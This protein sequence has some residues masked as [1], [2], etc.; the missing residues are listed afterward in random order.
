[1][2]HVLFGFIFLLSGMTQAQFPAGWTGNYEGEM[3][4]C[5]VNRPNDTVPVDFILE[6]VK[7]DAIWRYQMTYRSEKYGTI[8]KDYQIKKDTDAIA[9]S[10]VLDELN[11]IIMELTLMNN[12][13]YGMYE[14]E[15]TIYTTRLQ[16][17]GEALFFELT[18]SPVKNP[19]TT[20]T[21]IDDTHIIEAKSFKPTLTQSVHL[22]RK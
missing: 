16:K 9:S 12:C 17:Q 8:V 13:F 2:K 15:G 11:G 20:H 22:I 4:L 18:G 5:F 21:N 1:M 3:I 10:Y 7:K 14:V 6:D 19:K